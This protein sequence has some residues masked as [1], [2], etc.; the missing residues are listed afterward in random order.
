MGGSARVGSW[1]VALVPFVAAG[2]L[3]VAP[4]PATPDPS[5]T[6]RVT[7]AA[8]PRPAATS[9]TYRVRAGDTLGGFERAISRCGE[10]LAEAVP[11]SPENRNE[12]DDRIV[13]IGYD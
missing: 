8:S 13:L 6:P 12:L 7:A 1:L 10:I 5:P 9:R 2:C 4:P 11:K 3:T